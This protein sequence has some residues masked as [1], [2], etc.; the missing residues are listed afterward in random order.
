MKKTIVI[1]TIFLCNITFSQ[2]IDIARQHIDTL[3]SSHFWGRGYTRGGL[4]K[5]ANYIRSQFVKSG[6]Q[7]VSPN[8]F[9]KFS[10][11]VNTFPGVM[12]FKL[13]G[14][15]LIPGAQYIVSPESRGMEGSGKLTRK[16]NSTYIDH[17][18]SLLIRI[19]DKLIWSVSPV[20]A[21]YTALDVKLDKKENDSTLS[22][23]INIENE[24]I[25]KFNAVNVCGLIKGTIRPDSI[26]VVAA[27]YDHLGGMGR[28]TYF[29]GANDNASG[30]ALMLSL[31]DYYSK[32]PSPYTIAFIAFAAE[33]IGLV[34]SKY[35]VQ[36][37]LFPLQNIIFLINLDLEGTGQEGITVVNATE[38][39]DHFNNL[40]IINAKENLISKIN[41]RGKAANSDHYWFT[42]KGVP[43]FFIYTLG[44][45][46]AYHD[47]HDKAET[48]PLTEFHD[49]SLLLQKFIDDLA[50]KQAVTD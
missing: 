41:A 21:D 29:P 38:F 6:L 25:D 23:N 5:A 18:N 4:Q 17:E 27:H 15:E 40:Q 2:N 7:P 19:K 46:T 11:P 47:I 3:S 13:N 14:R 44:G 45:I 50:H 32:N 16:D 26:V 35:F 31:V 48:L 24:V 37:P 33:E 34:G 39:K 36:H 43:S 9:Q 1:V 20:A 10:F 28:E 12:H 22:Y 49:L 8:Y 42:Q 30:I